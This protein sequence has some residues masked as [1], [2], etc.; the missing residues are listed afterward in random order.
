M[1]N[2]KNCT[3]VVEG[4]DVVVRFKHAARFDKSSSGKSIIVA[5]TGGSVQIETP[6]G[7]LSCGLNAY[8]PA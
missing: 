4:E 3:V 5:S 2:S 6:S 1:E 7:T 8:I